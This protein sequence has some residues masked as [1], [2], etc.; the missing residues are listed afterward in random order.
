MRS[1]LLLPLWLGAACAS[2]GNLTIGAIADAQYADADSSGVRHYRL[3]AQKLA[4]CVEELNR[5]ELDFVVHLGDLIDKDFASFD[6]VMPLVQR[7]KAKPHL[8]LG[9]HEFSVDEGDKQAVPAMMGLERRYYDFEREGRRFLVVDGNDLSRYAW[10]AGSA[11]L[12][13][14]VAYHETHARD[15]PEWNGAIGARQLAWIDEV[16]QRADEAGED[17]FLLCHFPIYPDEVGYTLWNA[18]EVRELLARHP[19]VKAWLA[20][21]HHHGEYV[22][23][24]GIHFLTLRGM[25]D[26]QETAYAI[27]TITKDTLIVKGFGREPDRVLPLR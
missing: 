24:K 19:S 10:P 12:A 16:L 27:L 17:A 5:H 3:S 21:H 18:T 22:A 15:R 25:V 7:L 6:V 2:P 11:Q 9:N 23:W 26:T 14:S 4:D 13:A 1:T 20:G 8:V